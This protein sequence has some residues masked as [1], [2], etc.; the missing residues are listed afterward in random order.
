MEDADWLGKEV[1]DFF[2]GIYGVLEKREG[3]TK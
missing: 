1:S 3:Y 2:L